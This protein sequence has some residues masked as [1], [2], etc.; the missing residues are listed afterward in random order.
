MK[1]GEKTSEK[2]IFKG[3]PYLRYDWLVKSFKLAEFRSELEFQSFIW[4]SETRGVSL[5]NN[6]KNSEIGGNRTEIFSY[7][8]A[9]KHSDWKTHQQIAIAAKGTNPLKYNVPVILLVRW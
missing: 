3:R 4:N 7:E 1:I 8:Y 2:L 6:Q 9:K 5:K